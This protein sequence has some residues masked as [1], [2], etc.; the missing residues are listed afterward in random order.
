VRQPTRNASN[1]SDPSYRAVVEAILELPEDYHTP[2]LYRFVDDR[3]YDEI[4]R[5]TGTSR[6]RVRELLYRGTQLLQ[7]QLAPLI[8]ENA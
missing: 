6:T 4:S 3:C 7:Q 1:A 2:L 8:E 5:R